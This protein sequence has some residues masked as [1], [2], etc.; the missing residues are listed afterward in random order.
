MLAIFSLLWK[1]I[2]GYT[3]LFQLLPFTVGF[4]VTLLAKFFVSKDIR[5]HMI[6]ISKMVALVFKRAGLSFYIDKMNYRLPIFSLFSVRPNITGVTLDR[7]RI[8]INS[9]YFENMVQE[10]ASPESIIPVCLNKVF[11]DLY[12]NKTVQFLGKFLSNLNVDIRRIDLIL[13]SPKKKRIGVVLSDISCKVSWSF[14]EDVFEC[15]VK[16]GCNASVLPSCLSVRGFESTITFSAPYRGSSTLLKVQSRIDDML[17]VHNEAFNTCIDSLTYFLS[18]IPPSVDSGGHVF[19]SLLST[20]VVLEVNTVMAIHFLEDGSWV[21]LSFHIPIARVT[22]FNTMLVSCTDIVVY[23]ST[24]KEQPIHINSVDVAATSC[25]GPS[26]FDNIDVFVGKIALA[27]RNVDVLVY[28]RCITSLSALIE[29]MVIHSAEPVPSVTAP[30]IQLQE[31]MSREESVARGSEATTEFHSAQGLSDSTAS[32]SRQ[33]E[34]K[35]RSISRAPAVFLGL[36]VAGID[37][38]LTLDDTEDTLQVVCNNISSSK[39]NAITCGEFIIYQYHES[40]CVSGHSVAVYNTRVEFVNES[41]MIVKVD[42]DDNYVSHDTKGD[43]FGL[44]LTITSETCRIQ[45]GSAHA[46]ATFEFF[47]Q[48]FADIMDLRSHLPSEPSPAMLFD[49]DV[50]FQWS[51]NLL[52]MGL[53]LTERTFFFLSLTDARLFARKKLPLAKSFLKTIKREYVSSDTW[54]SFLD[55]KRATI[56]LFDVDT[57]LIEAS[58][59][60]FGM[61]NE[62]DAYLNTLFIV[63]DMLTICQTFDVRFGD[64]LADLTLTINLLLRYFKPYV[65]EC[66]AMPMEVLANKLS[67]QLRGDPLDGFVALRHQR[68]A[69]YI[70][71]CLL[72]HDMLERRFLS[73]LNKECLED[74]TDFELEDLDA[75]HMSLYS[76]DFPL[77]S[78]AMSQPPIQEEALSWNAIEFAMDNVRWSSVINDW[79]FDADAVRNWVRARDTS[80]Q[81]VEW[82]AILPF[83]CVLSATTFSMQVYNTPHIARISNLIF[84]GVFCVCDQ[85]VRK[86][87]TQVVLTPTS[88]TKN[89]D[90]PAHFPGIKPPQPIPGVFEEQKVMVVDRTPAPVQMFFDMNLSGTKTRAYYSLQHSALMTGMSEAFERFIPLSTYNSPPLA[91]WDTLRFGMHGNIMAELR[92]FAFYL[93]AVDNVFKE[94]LILRVKSDKLYLSNFGTHDEDLSGV[95]RIL[96]GKNGEE[97]FEWMTADRNANAKFM[98]GLINA[99]LRVTSSDEHNAASIPF[100]SVNLNMHFKPKNATELARFRSFHIMKWNDD[101]TYEEL[102]GMSDKEYAEDMYRMYRS[103]DFTFAVDLDLHPGDMPMT[104]PGGPMASPEI[105][106]SL[107]TVVCS[108]DQMESIMKLMTVFQKIPVVCSAIPMANR[109]VPRPK[110]PLYDFVFAMKR[111][112]FSVNAPFLCGC[113]FD[114]ENPDK[115]LAFA[116]QGLHCSMQLLQESRPNPN[117][118]SIF[119]TNYYNIQDPGVLVYIEGVDFQLTNER[120]SFDYDDN[121]QPVKLTTSGLCRGVLRGTR[122]TTQALDNSGNGYGIAWPDFEPAY[123]HVNWTDLQSYVTTVD[124]LELETMLRAMT[125]ETDSGKNAYGKNQRIVSSLAKHND[126]L[127]LDSILHTIDDIEQSYADEDYDD[128]VLS[129][130]PP[131]FIDSEERSEKSLEPAQPDIGGIPTP[132]LN[133]A[134]PEPGLR[135]YKSTLFKPVEPPSPELELELNFIDGEFYDFDRPVITRITA[136]DNRANLSIPRFSEDEYR[137]QFLFPANSFGVATRIESMSSHLE[138]SKGSSETLMDWLK[139]FLIFIPPYRNLC[140]EVFGKESEKSTDIDINE[141]SGSCSVISNSIKGSDV[142]NSAVFIKLDDFQINIEADS[143]DAFILTHSDPFIYCMISEAPMASLELL[144]WAS[145]TK[146]LMRQLEF[147][148]DCPVVV[149]EHMLPTRVKET[150]ARRGVKMPLLELQL[151]QYACNRKRV[152]VLKCSVPNLSRVLKFSTSKHVISGMSGM[153]VPNLK[154][155]TGPKVSSRVFITD[156]F[157]NIIRCISSPANLLYYSQ[158]QYSRIGWRLPF[159]SHASFLSGDDTTLASQ[160]GSAQ[161]THLLNFVARLKNKTSALKP[162]DAYFIVPTISLKL[163]D[164]EYRL[165]YDC[166]IQAFA[167]NPPLVT[168]LDIAFLTRKEKIELL[169]KVCDRQS[170]DQL[171]ARIETVDILITELNSIVDGSFDP[172]RPRSLE[173]TEEELNMLMIEKEAI[174]AVLCERERIRR[175]ER[176][177]KMPGTGIFTM[178]IDSVGVSLTQGTDMFLDSKLTHLHFELEQLGSSS[179]STLQIG[180]LQVYNPLI[181]DPYLVVVR[182]NY[183]AA[184][185]AS[186]RVITYDSPSLGTGK[187]SKQLTLDLFDAPVVVTDTTAES[188]SDVTVINEACIR[189]Y[190]EVKPPLVGVPI[191]D[192][193]ELSLSPM[194]I[195]ISSMFLDSLNEFFKTNSSGRMTDI[196]DSDPELTRIMSAST[197]GTPKRESHA[198]SEVDMF[199]PFALAQTP[200][201]SVQ[202]NGSSKFHIT[203]F[204]VSVVDVVISYKKVKG[205][206]NGARYFTD[207]E[208]I[209]VQINELIIDNTTITW[210]KIYERL[211]KHFVRSVLLQ[212]APQFSVQKLSRVWPFSRRRNA[213]TTPQQPQTSRRESAMQQLRRTG[214]I[215]GQIARD[216]R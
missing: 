30:I 98:I 10:T 105:V 121:N 32:V 21:E 114:P 113:I 38:R 53:T 133:A 106:N 24:L 181:N 169:K 130:I 17:L 155:Y 95:S 190:F 127:T 66:P 4:I 147:E 89:I 58:D 135:P 34:V 144:P 159:E 120:V 8:R 16:C 93:A 205:Q 197:I 128:D 68:G 185:D 90:H 9:K 29:R 77:L 137:D 143:S 115:Y 96:Y 107:P 82:N 161:A 44:P 117:A 164:S 87:P 109:I 163:D 119:K 111:I 26:D 7:L 122:I 193:V 99:V 65:D 191:I 31:A 19:S 33:T 50:P 178:F 140:S 172:D 194:I 212:V 138:L 160:V 110:L 136:L 14:T 187:L 41:L 2:L 46:I 37:I 91:W 57:P 85:K 179:L 79:M 134:I 188:T 151:K 162:F 6:G 146:Q 35:H 167:S 182:P 183:T 145:L 72:R 74:L 100:M 55:A 206:D 40:N 13:D 92:D 165:A 104:S 176:G 166:I 102:L 5:I 94:D 22:G 124:D 67:F 23:S 214:G 158:L 45:T 81:H 52:T 180:D 112:K 75:L 64:H 84:S 139:P 149:D 171:D 43:P 70:E 207:F 97:P 25:I 177:E 62:P 88:T 131:A 132:P 76:Q 156:E 42:D 1:I 201:E 142:A 108:L 168:H 36:D 150:F 56:Q 125:G 118:F 148:L 48:F 101:Q 69:S 203:Y 27:A 195:Q 54:H 15:S 213:E 175:L 39:H 59:F 173:K 211:E 186:H 204:K 3:V 83:R 60:A 73:Q 216:S 20:C 215:F 174:S 86:I 208:D 103:D 61:G 196:I 28:E 198:M 71:Q 170:I 116:I 129:P 49:F 209:A 18:K 63:S 80:F 157:P 126:Q 51:V 200:S 141:L 78:A 153:V 210:Q 12:A 184:V 192:H 11:E 123:D 202:S 154:I 47:E 152:D 199:S 189:L